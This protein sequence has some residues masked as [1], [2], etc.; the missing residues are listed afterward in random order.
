[1]RICLLDT[2]Y[3]LRFLLGDIPSQARRAKRTFSQIEERKQT[4][5]VS[6]LVVNELTWILE[7]FYEKKRKDYLPQLISLISLKGIRVLE[8]KKEELIFIL[9]MALEKNLDFTDLYLKYF[10]RASKVKVAS[11]DK[12]LLKQ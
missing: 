8:I 12:K 5:Y 9:K 3:I 1:M 11:F 4:G 7:N 6:V 2:N 10:A